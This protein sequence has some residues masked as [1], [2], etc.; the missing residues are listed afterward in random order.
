MIPG[1]CPSLE[2]SFAFQP[3]VD[4]ET[5]QVFAY[6][7]LVR[8]LEGQSAGS[9]LSRI[10]AD[11]LHQ[12][13][14]AARIRALELAAS[15]GLATRLSLNFLPRSLETLPDAVTAT[16]EAASRARVP[17]GNVILE[18]TEGEAVHDGAG[19]AE[20]MNAYRSQGVRFAIDDFGA[21][22][23]GLNLLAEF[24]PDIVKLDMQ[25]VRGIESKGPRQAIVRAVVQVCD[26][27][28][29]DLIAE[30]VETEAEFRWFRRIGLTLFQGYYFARPAFES[31][32]WTPSH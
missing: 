15:L 12:F 4:T 2:Y 13:D 20:R 18:I 10:R 1:A 7:A 17:L 21:G 16:L 19:F 9:V 11:Q 23:S 6:E 22:Y 28:G 14:C 24:Q 29:I 27:L 3:I 31:L 30:G 32:Q 5:G 26:D 8:G 25:L